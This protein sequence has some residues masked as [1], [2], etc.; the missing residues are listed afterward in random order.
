[1]TVYKIQLKKELPIP[2][3]L[4]TPE[5]KREYMLGM[6]KDET[7]KNNFDSRLQEVLSQEERILNSFSSCFFSKDDD[8]TILTSRASLL[9]V[10]DMEEPKH[11]SVYEFAVD[12]K[13]ITG[14]ATYI[15]KRANELLADH[16][17]YID[18]LLT[19]HLRGLEVQRISIS[20]EEA[21][22]FNKLFGIRER[23][24][25]GSYRKPQTLSASAVDLGSVPT[26]LLDLPDYSFET[27]IQKVDMPY[28]TVGNTESLYIY[29]KARD[30]VISP[31]S[32]FTDFMTFIDRVL[33]V[34]TAYAT[35][36]EKHN[37]SLAKRR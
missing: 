31:V 37:N 16:T 9:F 15:N 29:E 2:S 35:I 26:E 18:F 5:E 13:G 4:T 33:P 34:A 1:M 10:D 11:Y 7:V 20:Q 17:D 30:E 22:Q 36:L 32:S 6:S 23:L 27:A 21:S 28:W 25:D 24:A 12:C 14:F 8:F 19:E 3:H